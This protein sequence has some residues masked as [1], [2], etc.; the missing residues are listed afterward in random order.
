MIETAM[1]LMGKKEVKKGRH[2][3]SD[4][5]KDDQDEEER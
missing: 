2:L 3:L 4:R 5:R 1:E